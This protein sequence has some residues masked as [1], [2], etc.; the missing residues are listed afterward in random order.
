M[1]PFMFAVKGEKAVN[2]LHPGDEKIKIDLVD[3][4]IDQ[5]NFPV[6]FLNNGS[7]FSHFFLISPR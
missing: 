6:A 3:D 2:Y 7:V 4:S 1:V 5:L